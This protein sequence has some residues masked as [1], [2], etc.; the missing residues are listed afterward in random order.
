MIKINNEF[1]IDSDSYQY[2]L[3]QKKFNQIKK[4]EYF[5]TVAYLGSI[6]E[7]IK[8]VMKIKQRRVCQKDLTLVG[9]LHEFEKINIEM[10]N[11][12]NEIGKDERL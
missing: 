9:A 11:I 1:Y 2:I 7:C 4:E 5:S 3:Q 12:L 10:K 6:D 8:E